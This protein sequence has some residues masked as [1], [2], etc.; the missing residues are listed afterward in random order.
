[1]RTLELLLAAQ[2]D[3]NNEAQ[4]T[5]THREML[6]YLRS[7][8]VAE[9]DEAARDALR[10][11]H[12]EQLCAFGLVRGCVCIYCL[13]KLTFLPPVVCCVRYRAVGTAWAACVGAPQR[14]A[15]RE[16][17][18]LAA[19]TCECAEHDT[20]HCADAATRP[21][22]PQCAYMHC[23]YI[24]VTTVLWCGRL[25]NE[26]G[27]LQTQSGGSAPTLSRSSAA[28]SPWEDE[29]VHEP[30]VNREEQP[31]V[32]SVPVIAPSHSLPHSRAPT[33]SPPPFNVAFAPKQPPALGDF[34]RKRPEPISDEDSPSVF[35]S[36]RPNQPSRNPFQT[37]TERLQVSRDRLTVKEESEQSGWRYA[38]GDGW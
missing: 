19:T 5:D 34:L 7:A 37:A 27:V 26:N 22:P 2:G 33:P 35:G 31:R 1:M 20:R 25:R 12:S 10:R 18:T 6:R 16:P 21:L 8:V 24:Q 9:S 29:H 36:A 17:H 13:S 30:L 38:G 23:S 11:L 32:L 3:S 28:Q 4:T 15:R 14:M